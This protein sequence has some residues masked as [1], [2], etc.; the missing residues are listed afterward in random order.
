MQKKLIKTEIAGIFFVIILSLFLQNL[1]SLCNR[2]LIGVIFGS[3]NDS[4]WESA[5]TMLFAYLVWSMI[6]LLS[7]QPP[8]RK[9]VIV[10][11]ITL[12]YLGLSYILLCLIFSLFGSKSHYIAEFTFSIICIASTFYL[13]Y[14]FVLSD[15]KFNNLFAPSIFLLLLFIA[16]YCSL[17]PFP[18]QNYIFMDRAT[19]LYGI[20]PEY[21]DEGA[22]VLDT[23]YY[24]WIFA[25]PL[26]FVKPYLIL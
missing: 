21:I 9:F 13:S 14:K 16:F 17:T 1:H 22:I 25:N 10:K 11:T 3:V 6:E 15:R 2:E 18:P 24:L 23:L 4:I 12:Y 26:F 20:I 8:F 5:K 19:T 7:I